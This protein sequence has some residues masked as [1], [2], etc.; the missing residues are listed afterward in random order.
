MRERCACH[1]PMVTAQ[2][3]LPRPQA[4]QASSVRTVGPAELGG[5]RLQVSQIP[6][7]VSGEEG[8]RLI[9][10]SQGVRDPSRR[11]EVASSHVS[12]L[13]MQPV[14][15]EKSPTIHRAGKMI[16]FYTSEATVICRSDG[17]GSVPSGY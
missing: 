14:K 4:C 17:V 1:S 10:D 13:Q 12:C 3:S 2:H 15:R 9:G 7:G 16:K 5:Q 11:M 8:I 6:A